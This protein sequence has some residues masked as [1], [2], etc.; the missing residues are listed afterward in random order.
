MRHL[1][2]LGLIAFFSAT[3]IHAA[4]PVQ[5]HC[6]CVNCQCTPEQHCGCYSEKGCHCTPGQQGCGR[7]QSH[8][9][10]DKKARS[11]KES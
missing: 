11:P 1:T 9:T 3:E 6:Q 7:E 2:I 5:R 4:E 10:K 8:I